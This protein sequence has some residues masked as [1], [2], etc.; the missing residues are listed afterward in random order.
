MAVRGDL[1][2]EGAG[3]LRVCVSEA[4]WAYRPGHIDLELSGVGFIDCSGCRTLVWIHQRARGCG[5][6]MTVVRPS[7]LVLRLLR[8]LEFD[9]ELTIRGLPE[10]TTPMSMEVN[11]GL[12]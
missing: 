4:L 8:L 1:D 12:N 10:D 9:R 11:P 2:A 6:T 5:G 7:S 3:E